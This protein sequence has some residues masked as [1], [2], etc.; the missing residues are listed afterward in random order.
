MQIVLTLRHTSSSDPH[1]TDTAIETKNRINIID[2]FVDICGYISP[3]Y[4]VDNE[5][6]ITI[7][8]FYRSMLLVS[9]YSSQFPHWLWST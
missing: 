9:Q 7:L 6:E 1:C 4:L 2:F 3:I 8:E 5:R